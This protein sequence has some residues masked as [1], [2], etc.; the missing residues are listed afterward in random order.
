MK[1]AHIKEFLN[2]Q[3]ISSVDFN[4]ELDIQLAYASDLMSDILMAVRPGALLLTGLTNNQVIRTGKV[5][6]TSA[7]VFVRG[8]N[9][10]AETIKLAEQYNIPILATKV[11]MFDACGIL[12][13]NGVKG[14][15]ADT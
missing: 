6:A 12:F 5:A 9:P 11:S 14:I 7:I 1:L 10:N 8:K 15:S 2:C 3:L 13:A 4:P